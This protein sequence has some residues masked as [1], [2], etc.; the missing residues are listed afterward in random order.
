MACSDQQAWVTSRIDLGLIVH[1]KFLADLS[2]KVPQ[3]GKGSVHTSLILRLEAT[4]VQCFRELNV[5]TE[6]VPSGDSIRDVAIGTRRIDLANASKKLFR[7]L[8]ERRR[9]GEHGQERHRG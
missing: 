6:R 9:C 1:T 7:F 2:P 8:G 3:P 4:P 5:K